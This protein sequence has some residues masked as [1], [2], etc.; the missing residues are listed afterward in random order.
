MES[1]LKSKESI[2]NE[3]KRNRLSEGYAEK[4]KDDA[5]RGHKIAAE[6]DRAAA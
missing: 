2:S 5:Q 1:D 3:I 4:Y 6:C